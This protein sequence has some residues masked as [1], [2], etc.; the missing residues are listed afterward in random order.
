MQLKV[1]PDDYIINAPM[2][3]PMGIVQSDFVIKAI[4]VKNDMPVPVR[5]E[6]I[7]YQLNCMGRKIGEF[8]YKDDALQILTEEF[9]NKIQH[10]SDWDL[11]VMIGNDKFWDSSQLSNSPSLLP[12]QEIGILNEYF[13]VLYHLPIDELK[14]TI[15]YDQEGNHMI[16]RKTL[17]VIV[18][19]TKN[20]YT[21]PVKG[22]WQVNGNYDCFGAHRT[23]YS[24]EFAF[25]LGKLDV[26]RI[27]S[28]DEDYSWYGENIYAIADGEVVDCF[29]DATLRIGF[30]V[31][32]ETDEQILAQ[33]N[34]IIKNYGY[35]PL[36][37]GNYVILKHDHEEYSLYGH[38]IPQ[39]L[40]VKKGD[41]VK[42]GQM[43]GKIGNTGKSAC[44]HLHF[45]LMNGPDYASFRGLPC[46]F[47]NIKDSMGNHLELINEEYTIISTNHD[48]T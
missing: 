26:D 9:P 44:P 19:R 28:K 45:Q 3:F 37:C 46:H 30:P 40:P 10:C 33:R 16:L 11:N 29:C 38:M 6:E 1:I 2:Y 12:G 21:F 18:Y 48:L 15:T 35:M 47:T 41:Y 4:Q 39:S 20:S 8:C 34:A 25:D 43:L 42:Q 24:M 31:D 22:V 32:E 36:Q 27:H 5:I 23:Q 13:I 17:P 7:N 14:I